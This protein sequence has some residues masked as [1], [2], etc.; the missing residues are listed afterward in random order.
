MQLRKIV[1][2]GSI[3]AVMA[4]STIAFAVDLSNYPQPFMSATGSPDFLVVVGE[5]AAPSDVV[6][7]IDVAARL[8]SQSTR[9]VTVGGTTSGM[10]VNGEGKSVATANTQV[11]LGDTLGKSGLR[12]TMT[13]DELP[14]LLADG[15]VSG[16][17]S[18]YKYQQFVYL[19]PSDTTSSSSFRVQFD[20]PGAGGT[21]DPDYTLGKDI[22]TSPSSTTYLY[23]TSVSFDKA[24]PT[25]EAIGNKIALFGKEYT[26]HSD[27][28]FGT[29]PK[30]VLAGGSEKVTLKGG[31]T[32][33]VTVGGTSY[34]VTYIGSSDADTGVV[35]VSSSQD[36]VDQGR[37]KKI[38]G[39][40]VYMDKVFYLSS[41]DQTQNS[42]TLLL[43]SD[44]LVLENG[45]KA[46]KGTNEDSI[47]GTSVSLTT[48]NGALSAFTIYTSAK[49]TSADF[50]KKAGSMADPLWESFNLAF[51]SITPALK[52]ATG[53]TVTVQNSGDNY[54]QV[55][56]T[57]YRGNQ[58]TVPWAYKSTSSGTSFSLQDTSAKAIHVVEN[59]SIAQDEYFIV[60]GGQFSHMYKVTGVTVDG[61]SSAN[62]ALSDVMSG[63]SL[64][65]TLGTDDYD[66]KVIDGQS[67]YF[68][69]VDAS[70]DTFLVT[71]GTNAARNATGSYTTV[72]PV[73]KTQRG[74][75]LALTTPSAAVD[76]RQGLNISLPTG[77]VQVLTWIQDGSIRL[78]LTA[79]NREDSTTSAC[80]STPCLSTL[81]VSD[82][83]LTSAN[84]T[85][86]RTSTGG[87]V[88]TVKG[89]RNSTRLNITVVGG[90]SD[91]ILTQPAVVLTEEKDDAGNE[92]SVVVPAT[93][94][95]S[96]SNN[97]AKAD[98][99]RF[100]QTV[101]GVSLG[102]NSDI[103]QYA[104]LWGTFIE[105]N[106]NGQDKVTI[107]YPDDQTVANVFVLA[108]SA[109]VLSSG[110][111][112]ATM[113][114]E[115][116][117]VKTAVA[118]LD[119]E[120]GSTEK[121]TSNMILVGGPCVNRL[122]GD[123]LSAADVY[124]T[125]PACVTKFE[126]LGYPAGTA[127]LKY[128]ADPWG[129]TKAALI[130]AGHGAADTRAA[131]SVL[132][133]YDDFAGKLKGAEVKVAGTT[134]T[135]V[136]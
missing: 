113:V 128:L 9:E 129:T 46:K 20:K 49:S 133:K 7:A 91:A 83:S 95:A 104:D 61:T 41:T 63:T 98:A 39:L 50:V 124:N 132:M 62:I 109:S 59:Q 119:T 105:R 110:G 122:V 99:P 44:K 31:E 69:G 131:A 52:D 24:L 94:E 101:T 42:G 45:A 136:A 80:A 26:I 30:L 71:W 12:N 6:G 53:D 16:T 112:S 48:S 89:D 100:T 40:D 73:I 125:F 134:V 10:T 92:Y 56:F 22:S 102:S 66:Q 57:D 127:M 3:G 29:T 120:V 88:Y 116:V 13:K 82:G 54:V 43:G 55:T 115:A 28:T 11:F 36:N 76:I 81:N 106:T 107:Y 2:A 32:L 72:Y 111:T 117:P 93:T 90:S 8:G 103:T 15:T 34:Q 38:G 17:N 123:V 65:V 19:T 21:E 96:G 5:K 84:I 121:S 23:R 37:S 126:S 75:R 60:D 14:T 86:G 51:N 74:G 4:A 68:Q 77:A 118:K 58:K 47:D 108:K 67:Y 1:A 27:T 35:K 87:L 135:E 79:V 130:V 114:K 85:L 18:T 78:N 25:P 97:V 33:T 64:T 70:T